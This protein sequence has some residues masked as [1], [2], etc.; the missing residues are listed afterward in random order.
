MSIVSKLEELRVLVHKGAG[1]Y[2]EPE[3]ERAFTLLDELIEG[4]GDGWVDFTKA[5]PQDDH[6]CFTARDDGRGGYWYDCQQF[7]YSLEVFPNMHLGQPDYWKLPT[8][9]KQLTEGDK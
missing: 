7:K 9:P 8:P 3:M 6:W 5:K 2:L 1:S 4:Q